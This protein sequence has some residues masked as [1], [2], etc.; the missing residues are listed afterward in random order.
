[1]RRRQPASREPADVRL[2]TNLEK[3]ISKAEEPTVTAVTDIKPW[4]NRDFDRSRGDTFHAQIT[5]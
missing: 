4:R 3:K 5:A 2:L 1:M